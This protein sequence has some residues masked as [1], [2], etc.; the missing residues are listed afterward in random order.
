MRLGRILL[1]SAVFI[2]AVGAEH[3]YRD[4]CRRLLEAVADGSSVT[5][6]ASVL[7]A[8]E[9]LHQRARRTGNR[10]QAA[11]AARDVAT[12]CTLHELTPQD[13]VLATQL[14]DRTGALDAADACHAAT[15]LHRD[16]PVLVSPD[17]AF[18]TVEGL[19]RVDPVEAAAQL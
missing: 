7:A 3:R 11:V 15:A 2:Y 5:G 18:D 13:L 4:P 8:Q 6:E 10:V 12:F 16:I 1:D 19:R 17:P 9:L 14:F